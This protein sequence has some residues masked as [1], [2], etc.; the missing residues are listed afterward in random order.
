MNATLKRIQLKK[1]SLA[2]LLFCI[3]STAVFSQMR[4]AGLRTSGLNNFAMVYKVQTSE[5][6]YL[7]H[8]L[9]FADVN[10]NF[11]EDNEAFNVQLAYALGFEKRI[12]LDDK[13]MFVHGFEPSFRV[14]MTSTTSNRN[15]L[16]R[17]GIGYILGFQY[18]LSDVFYVNVETIPSITANYILQQE[19]SNSFSLNAGYASNVAAITI[20][21]R[22]EKRRN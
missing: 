6:R 20:A 2:I 15:V 18:N 13:L 11:N 3:T 21:Y 12:S 7:A 17:P 10:I 19:N 14:S 4:E 8:K 5:N 9:G 16:L 22:F 1:V